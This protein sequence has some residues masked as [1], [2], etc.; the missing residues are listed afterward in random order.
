MPVSMLQLKHKYNHFLLHFSSNYFPFYCN[1]LGEKI[2][3]PKNQ[4]GGYNMLQA[5]AEIHEELEVAGR[6]VEFAESQLQVMKKKAEDLEHENN[7]LIE[8]LK[9]KGATD[10]EIKNMLSK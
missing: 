5:F 1:S 7:T 9:K 4:E 3:I 8:A 2:E 6:K 10:E